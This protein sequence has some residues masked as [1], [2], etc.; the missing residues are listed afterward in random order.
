MAYCFVSLSSRLKT[1]FSPKVQR[2]ASTVDDMEMHSVDVMEMHS[3]D[4]RI[5]SPRQSK[6]ASRVWCFKIPQ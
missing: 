5:I 2:E 1:A 4:G 6:D 3:V